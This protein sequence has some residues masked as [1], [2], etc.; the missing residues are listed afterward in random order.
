MGAGTGKNAAWLAGLGH[1]VIAV[2][3]STAFRTRAQV[4]HPDVRV[5]WL[6]DRLP[7]LSRLLRLGIAADAIVM[8]AVWQHVAPNDRPRAFRK[9]ASLLRF[10]GVLA[11]TLRTGPSEP[12]RATHGTS[13]DEIEMLARSAG[14]AVARAETADD[15][16]GRSDVSWIKVTLRLS[17]DGTGALPCCAI[18][19]STTRKA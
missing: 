7:S 13:L 16:L 9:L 14:M 5:T 3:P 18:S 2:E 6:D 10:G 17:D 11:M 15:P 19:S 12:G 4:L 8:S 1:A